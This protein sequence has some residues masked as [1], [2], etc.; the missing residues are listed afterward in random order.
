MLSILN[1]DVFDFI[2]KS[3]YIW[4]VFLNNCKY[5]LMPYLE[6]EDKTCSRGE[7]TW[8]EYLMSKNPISIQ[9]KQRFGQKVLII[10][11]KKYYPDGYSCADA[12][13]SSNDTIYE[14]YG[15]YFHGCPK[16]FRKAEDLYNKTIARENIFK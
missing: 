16:C 4:H 8:L 14:Y 12:G 3:Q 11:S 2:T 1:C 7:T 13:F 5:P 9:H 15:C 10:N 6:Y